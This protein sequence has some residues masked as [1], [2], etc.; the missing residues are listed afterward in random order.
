MSAIPVPVKAVHAAKKDG[1]A[2][3]ILKDRASQEFIIAVMGAVGC[4]LPR[5]VTEFD[6]QLT[7]LGYKVIRIKLSSFISDQ[8]TKAKFTIPESDKDN[9]YLRS[10]TG[11]NELRRLYGNEVMAKY[12]V[13]Q[14]G[15]HRLT[16]DQDLKDL[17]KAPPRIAYIIDQ[18]KHPDEVALLRTVYRNNFYLVG[19][20][21]LEA[22]RRSRLGDDGIKADVIDSIVNRDRKESDKYGQQL[23]KAFKL[24]DYFLHHPLGDPEALV[25]K[26]AKRF[27]DLVHGDNGI[28]PTSH[29][30]AM[31]VAYS[32]AMKSS[33]LSR[34]VG[35]AITD[36]SNRVVAV[37]TNDVPQ[38]RGGLYSA[39]SPNDDRCF[40][41]RKICENNAE[42]KLRK[43]KIRAGIE[44]QFS[45]IFPDAA[46]REIASKKIDEIVEIVFEQSGIPDLIE[47]SRAVHAEMDALISLSRG[48]GGSTVGAKLYA[49]TFPC[50]NCARHIIAAGIDRVYYIE[51]YEKSLAPAAHNDAIEVLDHDDDGTKASEKLKFVHFSGVGPRIYPEFFLRENGRKD[52][53]GKFIPHG[54]MKGNLPTKIIMEFIDSYRTFEVAVAGLFEEEFPTEPPAQPA[55]KVTPQP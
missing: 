44:N 53:E 16:I 42:K 4:G 47:F 24:A 18:I 26:Q 5:I 10:Q 32:T 1:K 7:A 51:P 50:H 52:D 55:V 14:I 31:Y 43:S 38:Y 34:Q 37:G 3:E 23:E 9:R 35:A 40:K 6:Q 30:Y 49:T 22:S 21:S 33:C 29:E 17:S 46:M 15:R 19:V 45:I 2:V 8:I 20:M 28:T 13:N 36:K 25:P 27:L 54:P 41:T 39:E 11:G 48:G 12:A